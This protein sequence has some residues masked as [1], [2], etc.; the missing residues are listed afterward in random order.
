MGGFANTAKTFFIQVGIQF[1]I[2]AVRQWMNS[3]LKKVNPSDMYDYITENNDLWKDIPENMISTIHGFKTKFG[4]WFLEFENQINSELIL[5][6]MKDD[7]P[8]LFS[9]LINTPNGIL[10]LDSQIAKIKNQLREM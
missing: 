7:H 10:W 3:E 8:E 4:K 9:M 6:W 2:N 5:K 1:A